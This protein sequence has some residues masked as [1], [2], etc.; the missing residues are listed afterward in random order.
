MSAVRGI[1]RGEPD[2]QLPA[3]LQVLLQSGD[4]RGFV[5]EMLEHI[6]ECHEIEPR[7][8]ERR[9]RGVHIPA[10]KFDGTPA[11]QRQCRLNT[12]FLKIK[13]HAGSPPVVHGAQA[14]SLAAADIENGGPRLPYPP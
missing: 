10:R 2:K 5:I 9:L 1:V 7:G 6:M 12:R 3:R 13:A 4:H 11:P 8:A 14:S